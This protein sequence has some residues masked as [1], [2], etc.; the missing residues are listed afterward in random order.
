M[1]DYRVEGPWAGRPGA[2][3]L[4]SWAG[5][6]AVV[7]GANLKPR[8]WS[9]MI[10]SLAGVGYLALVFWRNRKEIVV[11]RL[12]VMVRIGPMALW[13]QERWIPKE[14]IGQVYVRTFTSAWRGGRFRTAGVGL[15]DGGWVELSLTRPPHP[16]TFAEAE[17]IAKALDWHLTVERME[18]KPPRR[19]WRRPTLLAVG[20]MAAGLAVCL[21]WAYWWLR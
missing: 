7:L 19:P 14:E 3:A 6:F 8:E 4:L 13:E 9:A 10:P 20:R 1:T 12:G 2:L 15:K 11:S 5:L 16:E 17:R 21:G 18:G